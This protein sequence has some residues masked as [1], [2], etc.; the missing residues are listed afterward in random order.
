MSSTVHAVTDRFRTHLGE[1]I[2]NHRY[3]RE[4]PWSWTDLAHQCA[5]SVCEGLLPPDM[6]H[7]IGEAIA[8]RWFI[9]GGRYLYYAGR[10]AP[11]YNNC[12]LLKCEEDTR[13]DWAALS[14]KATSCLMTGGGIGSVYSIYRP[15]GS[16]LNRTGGEASGPLPAMEMVNEIGRRVRQGGTR[17]SAIWA[18]LHHWHGDI[19][20]FLRIK[21]WDNLMLPGDRGTY[22]DAKKADYNFPCP[23]DHTNISVL[24]DDQWLND[25]DRSTNPHFLTNVRYACMNGE[26]GFSFNFGSKQNETLRNACTEVTSEDDSDVCNLGSLNL[27]AIPDANALYDVTELAI[28]FLLCG[29]IRAQLPYPKI[30]SVREKNRRLGLGLMGIHEWLLKRGYAYEVTPELHN[31]L[32]IYESRSDYAAMLWSA[33]LSISEPVAKRAIA[34]TGT[35]GTMV[36]TTT[37]I[38]P[39]FAVAY[40]RRYLKDNEHHYQYVVDDVALSLVQECGVDPDAIDTSLTLAADPERRIKFQADVQD[41]VDMSISSTINLPAWGSEE[42]NEDTLPEM[43]Q[44]ISKYAPRLR[45]IT[46]YPDGARGGQPLTPV[47]FTEAHRLNGQVIREASDAC[48]GGVCGI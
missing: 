3:K 13:E 44:A 35:I 12:Y 8:M 22:G 10:P 2:F 42:N 7:A 48:A 26:P 31:W 34:P 20:A 38:E 6:V 25:P 29:T 40:K 24:Y 4:R 19:D 37:G 45:G 1:E 33:K 30:N 11:F 9:P 36:G 21:D 15:K 18:G 32:T 5:R 14:H 46:C 39:L 23:L 47:S 43:A 16:F 27:G 41:Y 17:R 28:A